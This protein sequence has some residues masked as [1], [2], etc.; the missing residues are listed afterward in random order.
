TK[1]GVFHLAYN[2]D[3]RRAHVSVNLDAFHVAK[4]KGEL[5]LSPTIINELFQNLIAGGK[6]YCYTIK[7]YAILIDYT[8]LILV[9]IY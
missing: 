8:Q 5:L 7:I 1:L 3:G 4:I 6:K 2:K 9:C